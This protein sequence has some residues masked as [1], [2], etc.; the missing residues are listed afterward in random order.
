MQTASGGS[1]TWRESTDAR[2]VRYEHLIGSNS[3]A[4]LADV[5]SWLELDAGETIVE[6]AF[7]AAMNAEDGRHRTSGSPQQ[8]IDRWR[9]EMSCHIIDLYARHFAFI[10]PKL[11][12]ELRRRASLAGA[13]PYMF[14]TRP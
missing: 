5:F 7:R 11:G 14:S 8:S 3:H 4:A 10:M 9:S 6:N 2:L 13:M 1:F 12:Y